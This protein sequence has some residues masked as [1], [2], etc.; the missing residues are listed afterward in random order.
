MWFCVFRVCMIFLYVCFIQ[1][2]EAARIQWTVCGL[3]SLYPSS[4]IHT[5]DG[6][7]ISWT[8]PVQDVAR[9]HRRWKTGSTALALYRH[10]WKFSLPLNHFLC[11][12]CQLFRASRS[13]WQGVVCDDL[14]RTPASSSTTTTTKAAA[15]AAAATTRW[16]T[17]STAV[18]PLWPNTKSA[19]TFQRTAAE[20]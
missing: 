6:Q 13:H 4:G 2:F 12:H 3:Q 5:F 9:H 14:V 17:E 10:D 8:P 16:P 20:L 15:A 7:H 18:R 1:P 11:P 19:S